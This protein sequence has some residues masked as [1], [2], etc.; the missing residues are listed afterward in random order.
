MAVSKTAGWGFDPLLA[1]HIEDMNINKTKKKDTFL[2][3]LNGT[4][5]LALVASQCF[6]NLSGVHNAFIY[7]LWIAVS[8]AL[9]M[10]TSLWKVLLLFVSE[11]Y[12][13]LQKVV[14]PRKDETIQITVIVVVV[15]TTVGFLLWAIDS[16]MM[17]ILA[18]ITHIA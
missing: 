10:L 2:C 16:L 6:L 3:V 5:F 7:G 17:W 4:L 13:E 12:Q 9:F 1:C 18:K 15:V 14:W 11:S 8:I